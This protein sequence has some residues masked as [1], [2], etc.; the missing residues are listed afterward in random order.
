M[1][2]TLVS[3]LSDNDA[4]PQEEGAWPTLQRRSFIEHPEKISKK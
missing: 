1:Q 4:M 2:V 3:T